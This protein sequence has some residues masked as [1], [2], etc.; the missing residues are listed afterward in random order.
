MD[1]GCKKVTVSDIEKNIGI[2]RQFSIFELT[3][4]L[5][6]KRSEKAL[7]IAG[8]I[9]NSAKFALPA[10]V[11]V[12]YATFSKVLRLQAMMLRKGSPSPSDKAAAL[13]GENR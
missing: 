11:S 12:I 1:P 10:A 6:Y 4:E 5:C 3:K 2:S 13:S 9:G 8:Y 7:K